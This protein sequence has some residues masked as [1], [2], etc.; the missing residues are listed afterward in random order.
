MYIL[1]DRGMYIVYILLDRIMYIVYTFKGLNRVMAFH[2][3]YMN[4][5]GQ[6]QIPMTMSL[7]TSED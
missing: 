1:I 5:H 7:E 6:G 4:S 3:G 2:M